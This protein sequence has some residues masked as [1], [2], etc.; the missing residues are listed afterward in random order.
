MRPLIGIPCRAGIRGANP[1]KPV[2][3]SNQSYVQAIE[4][5][6]GL[7]VLIPFMKDP[8]SLR[9]LFARLDGLLLSGGIDLH[10]SSYQEEVQATLTETD[11]ELDTLELA[12]ARWAYQEDVPTLGI[13]R[14]MQLLNVSLGGTLYQ[15]LATSYKS[16]IQHANGSLPRNQIIH[17]IGIVPDSH[18]HQVL[19]VDSVMVNSIHHQAIKKLGK[20]ILASGRSDDGIIEVIEIP[21]RSFMLAVQGHPEELYREHPIWSRLFRAFI[22]ACS[23]EMEQQLEPTRS[24]LSASA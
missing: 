20:G 7:P 14:G 23:T 11:L 1:E 22:V 5:A 15:D 18:T 13:C 17:S 3:Y 16:D 24:E 2:Y 4:S 21:D 6:G 9:A 10:P 8:D 12:L 19:G